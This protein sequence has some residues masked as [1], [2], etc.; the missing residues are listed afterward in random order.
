MRATD[1][2]KIGAFIKLAFLIAVGVGSWWAMEAANVENVAWAVTIATA[3]KALAIGAWMVFKM[4]TP[5]QNN[6][7]RQA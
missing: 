3:L 1:H 2:L 5:L 4:K 6:T 7:F